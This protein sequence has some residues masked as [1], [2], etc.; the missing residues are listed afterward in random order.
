MDVKKKLKKQVFNIAKKI[1]IMEVNST[2]PLIAYQRK[3]PKGAK[4]LK[5]I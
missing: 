3:L 5:R 4:I 2:C 1:T